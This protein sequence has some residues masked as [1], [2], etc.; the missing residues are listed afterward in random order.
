MYFDHRIDSI[1]AESVVMIFPIS[2]EVNGSL[3]NKIAD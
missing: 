2:K 1:G 3:R